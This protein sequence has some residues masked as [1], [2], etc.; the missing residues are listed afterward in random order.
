MT[1]FGQG[2]PAENNRHKN[3]QTKHR[4]G[5]A[6]PSPIKQDIAES[7]VDQGSK[8]SK[9]FIAEQS[10]YEPCEQQGRRNGCCKR[11]YACRDQHVVPAYELRYGDDHQIEKGW[12]PIIQT[13]HAWRQVFA[14]KPHFVGHQWVTRFLT[15]VLN[16][17]C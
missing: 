1:I 6:E 2:K 8:G 10:P 5:I 9:G 13:V 16:R 4:F 11:H 15:Y 12:S 17:Q 14:V 7:E 3:K